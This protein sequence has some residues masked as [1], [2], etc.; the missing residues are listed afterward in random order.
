MAQPY[1][2]P[3]ITEAVIEIRTEEPISQELLDR[4]KDKFVADYPAPPQKAMALNVEIGEAAAKLQQRFEH[5]KLT[6]ADGNEIATLGPNVISTSKLAPYEG[7]EPFFAAAKRNWA[8][9]KNFVGYK[10]IVRIGVRYINRID[11]PNPEAKPIAVSDYLKFFIVMPDIGAP[12]M[13]SFAINTSAPL[14]TDD[15]LLI[16]N[17]SSVASPLVKAVSFILDLDISKSSSVPQNED[18]LWSFVGRV[19]DHKN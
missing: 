15:C 3:P 17:A 8:I 1:K 10:K 5:Y 2:R 11:V 14:G 13:E 4:L 16:L 6:S 7:W 9:W 18:A 19:R 12:P